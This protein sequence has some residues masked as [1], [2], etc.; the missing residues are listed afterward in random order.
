MS[1]YDD[2]DAFEASSLSARAMA[3][4]PA[5]YLDEL[6][7]AQREAVEAL[8]GPVLMLAGAG[9]GKTKA[10]TARVVHLL[11]TGR[12]RPNEILSVTFTNKAAREM[13]NRISRMLGQTVEGMPW[14]GTFH[15]ICV[16]LLRRHAEL[17]GLKS[18]FTI[19]DTDDQIR[20]LK[21]LIQA[22]GIDDK[23]WP[24]RQLANIIDGWKNRALTP[25][26]IPSADAGAY[27]YAGPKLYAQYQER[28]R[29]LNA[30]DFGD[31]LLHMVVIFQTHED[32][33]E[34]YQRWFRY[35]LVDEYQDT[36]V[37]QYMWLRLLAQKHRNICCVGDDDQSIYG[38]RGA[39][40]GN[41][42]RFEKDFE[43]AHVVRLEQNY[44][45]TPHILAAASSVIRG[46]TNRLGKELWTEAEDGEKVRLI[47]HWDGEEE[48]R[49][50]GEEIEAQQ[51]GTRGG[52]PYSLDDMAILVRASHQMRAFE[53]RF[54]TIGLPY[55][56]IGGP[57]F[58]E[59]MEIRDAMAYF[60]CVV[61]PDDD[62]A[63]ERIVNTP[64][65][66]L[67]DKA[68][69][70]IQRI[71][72]ENGVSLVNGA[73]MA[74]EQ[75]AI[76]GKG[77]KA[78]GEL[79]T[80]ASSWRF[81]QVNVGNQ[82]VIDEFKAESAD[83]SAKILR[84]MEQFASEDAVIDDENLGTRS[85]ED[86]QYEIDQLK[87]RIQ[88]LEVYIEILEGNHVRF[89]ELILDESGYTE[90]WQNDKTPEAPG[91]LENL[92]ELVKALES[93]ENLQGFLEH[94]SLV[95]DNESDDGGAKVSIMTLHAAKGLEFPVVFLPG[96]EDG[97]FP[98]QRSM[99]ESGVK[100][101]EEERRLAYVGITRA[102]ELCTISFAGNRRVFGQWQSQM[103]S[104]FV[105][106]L[107]EDHVD[108]LTPPGL[109]G[110]GY[111][112]A[113]PTGMKSNLETRVAEA[114]VYNSPGWRRLQERQSDRP[115][116]QPRESRNTVIDL[117]AVSAYTTG[118]RVFHNK[119]GYGEIIGIEGDKLEIDFEKAGTKKVVSRF[120]CA[121]DDVPF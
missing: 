75:G 1:S 107:P 29:E 116:S 24:A 18:N 115:V 69:Q 106:E 46:N 4:R 8:D 54:L 55:R 81:L 20:L 5:P 120:I 118:E 2:F 17:V 10:L 86:I 104:R 41:I 38:W 97:L 57:R 82:V 105:D 76:K 19:L 121:A 73:A 37:A 101:L 62:L 50:I 25:D 61:S 67:G 40:V 48:A 85:N 64:K 28:L 72:R 6:N 33:L 84:L 15:S 32:V 45:S 70:T 16:K 52:R 95:M 7:P 43:G 87:S 31:L 65:R 9:T 113:A 36:N 80:R 119:F 93:F 91:R 34:Q 78:L 98:S 56:V 103:P 90:M 83:H 99:D 68:Q 111:G 114:N 94:V 100:G 60:R 53:D 74:V 88:V 3:A 77:A 92:K 89:A 44:R 35:I 63:F 66:G 58:Y 39:E 108:I 12:A 79:T 117:T 22:A 14:L 11:N 21:Q 102:E 49:W 109:Y 59:R 112:A 47:G 51:G 23:R 26:K 42:L 27:N 30:V 110:G 71:A 13:K 96:W